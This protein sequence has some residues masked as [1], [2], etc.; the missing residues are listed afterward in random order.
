MAT[1]LFAAPMLP[2]GVQLCDANGDPLNG[3]KVYVY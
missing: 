1:A 3:G 2:P